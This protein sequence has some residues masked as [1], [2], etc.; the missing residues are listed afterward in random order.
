M[1][2]DF[3]LVTLINCDNPSLNPSEV[4]NLYSVKLFERNK[5]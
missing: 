1:I 4:Y 5:K 3:L 2:G